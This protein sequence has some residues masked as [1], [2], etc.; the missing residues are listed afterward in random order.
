MQVIFSLCIVIILIYL[1]L[2]L[3]K[4]YLYWGGTRLL[5]MSDSDILDVVSTTYIDQET[6][7]VRLR[8]LNTHYLI[9]I[10]KNNNLLLDK[11]EDFNKNLNAN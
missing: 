1:V 8:H 11:H 3:M 6:K 10:S 9:L 5:N 2:K 7:V 4:R